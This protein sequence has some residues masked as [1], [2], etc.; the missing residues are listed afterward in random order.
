LRAEPFD[1]AQ[2]RSAFGAARAARPVYEQAMQDILAAAAGEMSHEGRD[3]LADWP[4][5][6]PNSNTR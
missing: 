1:G 5:S 3:K 2:L 4:S 6:R